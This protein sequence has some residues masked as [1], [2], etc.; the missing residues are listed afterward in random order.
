MAGKIARSILEIEST[1]M[2]PTS[3]YLGF[4]SAIAAAGIGLVLIHIRTHRSRQSD[5]DL[6]EAD[7][8][9]F[10]H[11]Y[12]RRMQTSALLITLGALIGLCGYMK[13]FEDSPVFATFYVIGLLL[14]SLWLILLAIS[15]VVA[16]RVYSSRIDRKSRDMHKN[17]QQ[18]LSEVREAH[19][20]EPK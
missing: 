5:R 19:G 10:D 2:P 12:A 11:Q 7:H 13:I 16:T 6:N 4:G 1:E 18:A 9:F 14:L 17:L 3:T 20:L 15:D 8:R